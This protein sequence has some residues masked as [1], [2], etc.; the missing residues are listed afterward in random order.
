MQ[1]AISVKKQV[2]ARFV[3]HSAVLFGR[4]SMLA[5]VL[6]LLLGSFNLVDMHLQPSAEM[7]WDGLLSSLFFLQHSG[8]IRRRFRAW[9]EKRISNCYHGAVF[10]LASS[11]ALA[12]V[13]VFW[14]SSGPPLIVLHG[15]LR[16]IARGVFIAAAAGI[17]WG[18]WSLGGFDPFG[19]GPIKD[20]LSGVRTQAQPLIVR[21]SYLWVRHPLYFFCLLMIWSCPDLSADRL[22][23]NLSWTVWIFIGAVLEEKDLLSEFG[24]GYRKYQKKV[25]MLIPWKGFTP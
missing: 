16:W 22:L 15:S 20:K 10:A 11:L 14:Q 17:G 12:L 8:M 18:Y 23:F 7:V 1:D 6:F 24:D 9:L 3:M 5:F 19:V 21:G 13:V 25:P 4:L 2:S